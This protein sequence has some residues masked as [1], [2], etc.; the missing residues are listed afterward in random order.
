MHYKQIPN[1]LTLL[2]I[3]MAPVIVALLLVAENPP[4]RLL[5]AILFTLAALTDFFDG[6]LARRLNAKNEFGRCFDP[7]A[8]KI[9]VILVLF[10]LAY[11]HLV[12]FIPA[13]VILF[14][15]ILIAGMREKLSGVNIVVKVTYLAK[16][17]TVLQFISIIGIILFEESGVL[18]F[19]SNFCLVVAAFLSVFTMVKYIVIHYSYFQKE[20]S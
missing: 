14:R 17:K 16:L 18:W 1:I 4:A 2:R 15:E 11:R 20:T 7:I 8:D 19:I 12:F 13:A 6:Y 5:C 3:G 9:L 10:T